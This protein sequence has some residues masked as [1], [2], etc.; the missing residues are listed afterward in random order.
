MDKYKKYF[1]VN[2]NVLIFLVGLMVVGLFF[3]SSLPFFLNE[4]DKSV[5]SQYLCD[6]VNGIKSG[7]DYL[8]VL[9]NGIIIN[10]LFLFFLWIL[11]ISI[12]GI[13]IVVFMF[14]YKCFIFGFSISSIIVNYG[15]KGVLF[16]FFYIFPHNAFSLLVYGL[17]SCFSLIF[18]MKLI[19]II[20]KKSDFN[21]RVA[22][23][24]YFR[25]FIVLFLCI[26]FCV[27]YETFVNPYVLRF[28]FKIIGV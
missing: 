10:G 8:D 21:L 26:I 9:K 2:K 24:K 27:L 7:C 20:F 3:G 18:S 5:V 12:V 25:M 22:F 15:F 19:G 1:L 13:P 14:F 16:A 23:N 28:I 11:G 6:F 4:N 17:V